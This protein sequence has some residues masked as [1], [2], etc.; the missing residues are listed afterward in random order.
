MS[1]SST[2]QFGVVILGG[3]FAGV[4]CAKALGRR[5]GDPAKKLVALISDE[6]FSVFQ[7]MLPEV[8]GSALNPRHVV[9]PLRRHCPE[10]TVLRATIA[11][12]DLPAHRL[13][14][15]PGDYTD[16]TE[17]KFDHLVITLGG[18]VDLSRVPGMPEHALLMKNV[19]DALRLRAA[20]IDRFEEASLQTDREAQKRLLTF[21]IVGGGYSGVETAGQIFDFTKQMVRA[22]SRISQD[23]V[24]VILVH[25][26]EHLLPEISRSLGDYTEKTLRERGME[27]MLNTRV[28]AITSSRVMFQG[29][30]TL[31][32]HTIVSTVGNAP[33]PLIT[34]LAQENNIP[35]ERGRLLT[36]SFLRVQG[37]E[38]LWAGGDAAAVP[39]PPKEHTRNAATPF[40]QRDFCPPTAQF[41]TRQGALLGRNV[42][43][44]LTGDGHIK[45]FSFSGLGELATIGHMAAVAEIFGLQ[46][47]GFIAWWMWRTIY[48]M[49]LPGLERKLRVVM[50]WSLDL[51]FPRDIAVLQPK[52]TRLLSEMHLES[53]DCLF[54][55]G[56]PARRLYILKSGKLELRD[57]AG[58][59][60]RTLTPGHQLG[61]HTLTLRKPWAFTAIAVEPTTLVSVSQ[62]V[63][64]AVSNAGATFDEVFTVPPLE[65]EPRKDQVP[66]PANA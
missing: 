2:L 66:Q 62:R 25:S 16:N 59:V 60:L 38:K 63:F 46:F 44:K 34:R 42:F 12:I 51:F 23:L 17:I 43:A 10:V 41:A 50:D 20:V 1:S 30:G 36:D 64:D 22:Y 31:E 40:E 52:P 21:V 9:N 8:A 4:D 54:H 28:S 18:I 19:G 53:G 33:N 45:E 48:L 32:T 55:A 15:E 29:G 56:D 5:L 58:K 39:M 49:K 47:H 37:H 7:P 61:K 65:L 35:L 26:G 3:G 24:R 6:N 27:I 57:K 14:I 11:S 13:V